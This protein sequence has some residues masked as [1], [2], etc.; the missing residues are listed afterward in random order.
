MKLYLLLVVALR[1][2]AG[3][4]PRANGSWQL[5][6]PVLLAEEAEGV[7]GWDNPADI[8]QEFGS[9][10][11]FIQS[12]KLGKD[13]DAGE[14][15][16]LM[17]GMAPIIP[18]IA[19]VGAPCLIIA[20]AFCIAGGLLGAFSGEQQ[21]PSTEDIM[22]AIEKGFRTVNLRLDA[23]EGALNRLKET[24]NHIAHDVST[25]YKWEVLGEKD[26]ATI[27]AEYTTY[28]MYA[29]NYEK[30]RRPSELRTLGDFFEH[31]DVNDAL[32]SIETFSAGN[33]EKYL[34][35]L[36]EEQTKA[37]HSTDMGFVDLYFQQLVAARFKLFTLRWTALLY[38]E[39]EVTLNAVSVAAQLADDVKY[40]HRIAERQGLPM[41]FSQDAALVAHQHCT[42]FSSVRHD[43]ER[44]YGRDVRDAAARCC[45][46]LDNTSCAGFLQN[47][48]PCP[49]SGF[50]KGEA[51]E[52]CLAE[53]PL[54]TT[55]TTTCAQ[56]TG[57][58]CKLLR[59]HVFRGP[60]DCVDGRCVCM[61]GFCVNTTEGMCSRTGCQRDTGRLCP[62]G[63]WAYCNSGELCPSRGLGH[64]YHCLCAPDACFQDGACGPAAPALLE[65]SAEALAL[66]EL[67]LLEGPLLEAAPVGYRRL[68]LT[69]SVALPLAVAAGALRRR[70]V[71]AGMG[72]L[73]GARA[74]LMQS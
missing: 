56:D 7:K 16:G 65:A 45:C 47:R 72:R 62:L 67:A 42:T 13:P 46:V 12:L 48:C 34:Q 59:C 21:A 40:F 55:T 60:T 27:N 10:G 57:G 70:E 20:G 17:T 61:D 28:M 8:A 6:E 4:P 25:L 54:T 2:A 31:I 66:P 3:E 30:E 9:I 36:K 50:E 33:V 35:R 63:A 22:N 41:N 69:C 58:T 18:M 74:P 23:I 52:A 5:V 38:K 32:I 64:M 14:I 24:M 44:I 39:R 19:P 71:R 11:D 51:L 49:A 43:V 68:V 15:A 29:S 73:G 1:I 37:A 53:M 26:L